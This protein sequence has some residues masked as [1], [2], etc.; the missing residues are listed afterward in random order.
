[1]NL[2]WKGKQEAGIYSQ[3]K[4]IIRKCST[5]LKRCSDYFGRFRKL[6]SHVC[7]HRMFD[8]AF[9]FQFYCIYSVEVYRLNDISSSDVIVGEKRNQVENAKCIKQTNKSAWGTKQQTSENKQKSAYERF[10]SGLLNSIQT[11]TGDGFICFIN[12]WWKMLG[13]HQIRSSNICILLWSLF[14]LFSAEYI[15]FI[16]I[17]FQCVLF[18]FSEFPLRCTFY[19]I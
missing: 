3:H 14:F 16:P 19:F 17:A 8:C 1:M 6:C 9:E 15:Q 5:I 11:H 13:N 2:G 10:K 12:A 7:P 4:G 18:F